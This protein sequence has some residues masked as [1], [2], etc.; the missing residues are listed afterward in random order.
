MT[1]AG[2]EEVE[3]SAQISSVSRLETRIPPRSERLDQLLVRKG[4]E[5]LTSGKMVIELLDSDRHHVDSRLV[6]SQLPELAAKGAFRTAEAHLD[7]ARRLWDS[8]I[9]PT[10]TGRRVILAMATEL[11]VGWPLLRSGI[12]ASLVGNWRPVARSGLESTRVVWDML[13]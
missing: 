1:E 3:K 12:I 6:D 5:A 2:D 9:S 13:S 8:R 7:E 4:A 11:D 10:L